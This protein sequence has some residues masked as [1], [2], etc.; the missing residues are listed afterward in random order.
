MPHCLSVYAG[1]SRS[2][3][4]VEWI[5][6]V[7]FLDCRKRE[8][9]NWYLS[10]KIC[11][12]RRSQACRAQRPSGCWAEEI[13]RR[14]EGCIPAGW[15][16]VEEYVAGK[17]RC[18]A[19]T[20]KE[21]GLGSWDFRTDMPSRDTLWPGGSVGE[22][23]PSSQFSSGGKVVLIG[24]WWRAVW[25]VRWRADGRRDMSKENAVLRDVRVREQ[26]ADSCWPQISWWGRAWARG[27]VVRGEYQW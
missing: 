23:A 12:G 11:L 9:E 5:R 26:D 6:A 2:V 10:A 7:M 19:E 15:G 3:F 21:T 25:V 14:R 13:E 8:S 24:R 18:C 17:R 4:G 1:A 16:I 27:G 22:K 20:E